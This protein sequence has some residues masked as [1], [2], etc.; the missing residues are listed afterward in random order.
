[1][2]K[3][4]QE[5]QDAFNAALL[6]TLETPPQIIAPKDFAA[7]VMAQIPQQPQARSRFADATFPATSY[8]RKAIFVGLGLL[9]ALMLVITPATRTSSTWMTFQMVLLAQFSIFVLWLGFGKAHSR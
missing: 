4:M 7:R 9:L 5:P 1:M 3:D 6:H 8:G 2:T